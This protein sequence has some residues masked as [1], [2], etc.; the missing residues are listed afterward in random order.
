[1][2]SNMWPAG[3]PHAARGPILNGPP[4]LVKVL[5]FVVQ[6]NIR[7]KITVIDILLHA[8]PLCIHSTYI[9]YMWL[10]YCIIIFSEVHNFHYNW[11]VVSEFSGAFSGAA[12]SLAHGIKKVGQHCSKWIYQGNYSG[13]YPRNHSRVYPRNHCGIYMKPQRDIPGKPKRDIPGKS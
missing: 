5:P 4:E 11:V 3:R 13:S 7:N 2:L 1:M 9:N 12:L 8:E 10:Y 6:N